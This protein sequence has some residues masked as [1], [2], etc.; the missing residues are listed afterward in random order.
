M[1]KFLICNITN[2]RSFHENKRANIWMFNNIRYIVTFAFRCMCV[3]LDYIIRTVIKLLPLVHI[4]FR[5]FHL[6]QSIDKQM[7]ARQVTNL[8]IIYYL[9]I[10]NCV[11]G[12][13]YVRL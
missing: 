10:I 3:P 12:C 9:L 8:Y 2:Q 7:V 4:C 1:N 5:C 6:R 11:Y 13:V